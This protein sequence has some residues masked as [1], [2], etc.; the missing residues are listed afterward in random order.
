M[1]KKFFLFMS[2]LLSLSG[3]LSG[4]GMNNQS[5]IT[6]EYVPRVII[7]GKWGTNAGEFGRTASPVEDG[8]SIAPSSLAVDS[9]GNIYILD[10]V[11]N[12]IQKFNNLGKYL[13]SMKVD[14]WRGKILE[15]VEI[16]VNGSYK[17]AIDPTDAEGKNIAMDD[18]DNLYYYGRVK[19][20]GEIRKFVKDKLVKKREVKLD[21]EKLKKDKKIEVKDEKGRVIGN[22]VSDFQGGTRFEPEKDYEVE[23]QKVGVDRERVTIKFKDGK[24]MEKEMRAHRSLKGKEICI[25]GNSMY[26]KNRK[27]LLIST[28]IYNPELKGKN[29]KYDILTKIF[30]SSG[31][32]KA[33]MTGGIG[34]EGPDGVIYGI[35]ITTDGVKIIKTERRPIKK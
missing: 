15:G 12:R 28:I 6:E 29:R 33:V 2:L 32:L 20:K 23:K 25:I 19:S 5:V 9:T 3:F 8:G 1:M 24:T 21:R 30:S 22:I 16:L 7:E 10:L 27:E 35:T 31:D 4:Q 17:P 34:N 11:N 14:G 26:L 13:L 18:D